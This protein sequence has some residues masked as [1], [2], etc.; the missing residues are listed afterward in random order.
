MNLDET[1]IKFYCQ[2]CLK[3]QTKDDLKMP[4]NRKIKQN[5]FTITE[6]KVRKIFYIGKFLKKIIFQLSTSKFSD[7][8]CCE[9]CLGEFEAFCNYRSRLISNQKV[10]ETLSRKRK[11][12]EDPVEETIE[13]EVAEI[14][15]EELISIENAEILEEEVSE[16]LWKMKQA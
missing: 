6:K 13:M 8:I 7:F 15:E 16:A 4:I 14:A 12:D 1:K 9:P 2:F 10:L 5:F 11:R 3:S